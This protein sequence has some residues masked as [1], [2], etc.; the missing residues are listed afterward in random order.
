LESATSCRLWNLHSKIENI[1]SFSYQPT[2][3][4]NF[5]F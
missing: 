1:T 2:Y 5:V 3:D 4:F